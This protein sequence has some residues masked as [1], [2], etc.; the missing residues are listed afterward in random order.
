VLTP[1]AD[2]REHE[3]RI[4]EYKRR[5]DYEEIGPQLKTRLIET[6]NKLWKDK[7]KEMAK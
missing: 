4:A 7:Q 5:F 2:R 6:E 1:P 3:A